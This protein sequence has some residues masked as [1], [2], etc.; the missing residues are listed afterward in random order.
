L[1]GVAIIIFGVRQHQ[2]I[3]PMLPDT[4]ERATH[5]L[6]RHGTSSLYA[7]LELT[8]GKV[9]GSLHERHRAIEF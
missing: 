5:D 4:P 6:E 2:P 9:I 1:D 7:A 8:T 3:L